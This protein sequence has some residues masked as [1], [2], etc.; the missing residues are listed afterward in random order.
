[1]TINSNLSGVFAPV[2]TPFFAELAVD[3]T[4]FV[5][6][7][8]WL[9]TQ[10]AGLAVFGTN[11]EGNSLSVEEKLEC[12]NLFAAEGIPSQRLMPGTGCCALPE[13]VKLSRAAAQ[14]G[15]AG[16]LMLP[17]FFYKNVSDEG[18]FASYSEVVERVGDR[19][20]KIVLYH[21]PQVSGIA[22][23]RGLIERLI[24]R[25]P[26]T[27]VGIKDSSGDMAHTRMLLT[28]FPDFRVFCGSEAFLLET[29]Q[30]GGAGCIS[31][32]ANINPAAIADLYGNWKQESSLAKQTALNTVRKCL[33]AYPMIPALKA[34]IAHFGSCES[35]ANVRPPLVRLAPEVARQFAEAITVAGLS[36]RGLCHALR[37]TI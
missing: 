28:N 35:F 11:S 24:H 16:V 33:E 3:S 7:C 10:G 37:G 25:Y 4:H 5:R 19:R 23:S 15:M 29:L 12:L 13:T 26:Q 1:M 20:L 21:I 27:V 14:A 32:T 36:M 34:C 22:I 6:F 31:A 9:L 30:G 17:P 8:R 18:L 2:V